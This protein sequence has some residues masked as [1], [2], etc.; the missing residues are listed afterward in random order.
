MHTWYLVPG[1]SGKPSLRLIYYLSLGEVLP[2]APGSCAMQMPNFLHMGLKTLGWLQQPLSLIDPTANQRFLK[3]MHITMRNELIF[4]GYYNKIG[5][6]VFQHGILIAW[7]YFG[8]C[9]HIIY[10]NKQYRSTTLRRRDTCMHG[11]PP[12]PPPPP[13]AFDTLVVVVMLPP[14]LPLPLP[15]LLSLSTIKEASVTTMTKDK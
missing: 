15:L 9:N 5:L 2:E 14:T 1:A 11:G 7:Q 12:P 4:D 10:V 6:N 8:K 3:N 13:P